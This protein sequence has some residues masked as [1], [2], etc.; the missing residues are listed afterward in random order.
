MGLC[1]VGIALFYTPGQALNFFGSAVALISGVT[2]ALYILFLDRFKLSNMSRFKLTMYMSTVSSPVLLCA[3]LA[4][5]S[6][7]M[8]ANATAWAICI[9]LAALGGAAAGVFFQL[10]TQYVGGERASILST[11]EPITSIVLGVL[12]YHEA[13]TFRSVLGTV[14]V[15]AATS[16]IA[17]LDMRSTAKSK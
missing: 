6:F 14:C 13:L 10:G 15:L 5:N 7:V 12:V 8:P 11:F 2:Y 1:T 9:L 17:V 4:T 16:M 3:A